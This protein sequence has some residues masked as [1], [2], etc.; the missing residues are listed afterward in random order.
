MKKIKLLIFLLLLINICTAQK[1]LKELSKY[2]YTENNTINCYNNSKDFSDTISIKHYHLL[3]V[4]VDS[5]IYHVS[6]N[7]VNN[8]IV[9]A[10]NYLA[11][12]KFELCYSVEFISDSML[13][14]AQLPG[15]IGT[16]PKYRYDQINVIIKDWSTLGYSGNPIKIDYSVVAGNNIWG[17]IVLAHEFGHD[18][19]L[20]HV[21]D[22]TNIMY[23]TTNGMILPVSFNALQASTMHNRASGGFLPYNLSYYPT[24]L[25][26]G[27]I[28]CKD[29]P[30]MPYPLFY[31]DKVGGCIPLTIKFFDN[32]FF[33][34]TAW[35]WHFGDGTTSNQKNPIHTYT[36][37]G[38]YTVTLG[39]YNFWGGNIIIKE[40]FITVTSNS[41]SLLVNETFENNIF[42]PANWYILNE[43]NFLTWSR[44]TIA[45]CIN[46]NASASV[47]D[48]F[49]F[50][51]DGTKDAIVTPPYNFSNILNPYLTFDYAYYNLYS[52]EPDSLNIYFSNDCS[53]TYHRIF[54]KGGMQLITSSDSAYSAF[55][56]D[57]ANDWKNVT[58]DLNTFLN[59][60]T[61][62]N[63]KFEFVHGHFGN[64][65]YLD[66]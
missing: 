24:W 16:Y 50:T 48:Y 38:T 33:S 47:N 5:G 32:S 63:F 9:N 25:S 36:T 52:F 45:K 56:P 21:T 40:G 7:N 20:G 2:D 17:G 4:V 49:A 29:N 3:I 60:Q 64:F 27:E 31:S 58:I 28:V 53:N 43:D 8:M 57:S 42:P 54:S 44:D 39:A 51:A 11:P 13:T 23:P 59:E 15:D 12:W 61:D 41:Y 65:L 55:I 34:P 18:F 19:Q 10:N 62:I 35:L 37:Q 14:I 22:S 26:F 66:N 46:G 30:I 1:I 6:L